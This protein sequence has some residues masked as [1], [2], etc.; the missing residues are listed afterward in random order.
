[1]GQLVVGPVQK[2]QGAQQQ[3]APMV[4][5]QFVAAPTATLVTQEITLAVTRVV[6]FVNMAV[7]LHL[8]HAPQVS[9][10]AALLVA[11]VRQVHLTV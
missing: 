9:L 1:M 2:F 11:L 10:L 4:M 7:L 3:R 6:G 5:H 8:Q